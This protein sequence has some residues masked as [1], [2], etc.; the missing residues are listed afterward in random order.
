MYAP[1]PAHATFIIV[2]YVQ[3]SVPYVRLD[4]SDGNLDVAVRPPGGRRRI[5]PSAATTWLP[6]GPD[7]ALL[8]FLQTPTTMLAI[9]RTFAQRLAAFFSSIIRPRARRRFAL[10][11]DFSLDGLRLSADDV[12]RDLFDLFERHDA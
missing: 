8:Y 4:L 5:F 12:T 1:Q 6:R 10:T 11:P 3:N 7:G 2:V 9:R